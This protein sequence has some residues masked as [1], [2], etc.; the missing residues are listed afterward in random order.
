MTICDKGGCSSS[1]FSGASVFCNNKRSAAVPATCESTVFQNSLVYCIAGACR[2]SDF[3]GSDVSCVEGRGDSDSC[4]SSTFHQSKVECY[5]SGCGSSVFEASAVICDGYSSC[6]S[7][8]FDD[9]S[10]C[11]GTPCPDEIPSCTDDPVGFCSGREINGLTCAAL[12]NPICNGLGGQTSL[13]AAPATPNPPA[14]QPPTKSTGTPEMA[15]TT[16]PASSTNF[17]AASPTKSPPTSDAGTSA[18]APTVGPASPPNAD[19]DTS[20]DTPTASPASPPN[21]ESAIPASPT[22]PTANLP[23]FDITAPAAQASSIPNMFTECSEVN[24]V[25]AVSGIQVT[26]PPCT[27]DVNKTTVT[28]WPRNGSV[29]VRENGSVVYTPNVGF[30]GLDVIGVETCNPSGDCFDATVNVIVSAPV[31]TESPENKGGG[32][33]AYLAA[34]AVIPIV[35]CV[36]GYLIYKKKK[37]ESSIVERQDNAPSF[38]QGGSVNVSTVNQSVS[39]PTFSLYSEPQVAQQDPPRPAPPQYP[40]NNLPGG[41]SIPTF[42]NQVPSVESQRPAN[43]AALQPG[44][45]DGGGGGVAS[46]KPMHGD[47]GPADFYE[48]NVKDQCRNAPVEGMNNDDPPLAS[49]V[50]VK[51]TVEREAPDVLRIDL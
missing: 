22:S 45:D 46:A 5:D 8:T 9:C 30:V 15:V 17:P 50:V 11:D 39:G 10:C 23:T 4:A 51:E 42:K 37:T 44:C 14:S 32:S 38:K 47:V 43:A 26:I 2:N 31:E 20:T 29:T 49:A 13:P 18:D 3:D 27:D 6:D 1:S 16:A 35:G 36:A 7:A 21:V 19:A 33:Q 48:I 40:E 25:T 12:G 28:T 24:E 41:G 34:L